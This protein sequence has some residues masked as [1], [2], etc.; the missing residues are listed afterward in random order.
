MT[1]TNIEAF[2]NVTQVFDLSWK[3]VMLLLNQ[4]LTNSEKQAALQAAETFGDDHPLTYHD[5]RTERDPTLEPFPRGKQA[6]PT[7]DPQWEPDTAT[8]NW[9]R[10]HS[11]A[12]ILEGLRRTKTK[13]F[14]YSKLSTIS[15]NLE[16]NPSAFLERLREALIKYT[17]IGPDSFEAEILLKDKFITQAAPD[18]RRKLQKLAIGPEGTLDQ[19]FKVA[20]SVHYNW[21][22]EE[23]QDKER[24]IRKKAEALAF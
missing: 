15:Y 6:V 22:Q 12:Y 14:N 3:N 7:A 19:L 8:G 18:I 9:Q 21:D 17:S 16:E 2:Q 24:K 1:L 20:N 23:A 11:L 4:P 13:P 5:A 10:K